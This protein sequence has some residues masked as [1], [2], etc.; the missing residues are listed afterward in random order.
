LL[1]LQHCRPKHR[2]TYMRSLR[3][4]ESRS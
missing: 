3:T 1:S 2:L 4:C